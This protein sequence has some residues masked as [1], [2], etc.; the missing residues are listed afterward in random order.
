MLICR[1]DKAYKCGE[2]KQ[3]SSRFLQKIF[4]LIAD[5]ISPEKAKDLFEDNTFYFYDEESN[6]R[7]PYT[8]NT[9]LVGLSITYNAD[10]T[11]NIT[12]K[13]KRRSG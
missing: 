6:V 1:D 2:F 3:K 8:Y 13:L 10:S 9:E 11:C 7:F 12:M 4:F 5:S